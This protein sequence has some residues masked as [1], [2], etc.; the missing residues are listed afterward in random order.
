[1]KRKGK[2]KCSEI[3]STEVVETEEEHKQKQVHTN[4]QE[5]EKKEF[6]PKMS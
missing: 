4:K 6:G 5:W 3:I 2:I 1:M